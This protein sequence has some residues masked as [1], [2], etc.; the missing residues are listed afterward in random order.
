METAASASKCVEL[1]SPHTGKSLNNSP[2]LNA[3][4]SK[5]KNFKP[6]KQTLSRLNKLKQ[7]NS[8]DIPKLRDLYKQNLLSKAVTESSDSFD[9]ISIYQAIA[10]SNS[11]SN[12]DQDLNMTHT[13]SPLQNE[14]DSCRVPSNFEAGFEAEYQRIDQNNQT[15]D[16][17]P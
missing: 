7:Q 16:L 8:E 2:K 14:T 17:S 5:S 4:L 15:D 10:T 12:I 3:K 9:D 6:H 11:P 1:R 13:D